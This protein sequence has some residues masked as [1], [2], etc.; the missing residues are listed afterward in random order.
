ML[1]ENKR[2]KSAKPIYTAIILYFSQLA[3]APKANEK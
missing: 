1:H 3:P 2:Y